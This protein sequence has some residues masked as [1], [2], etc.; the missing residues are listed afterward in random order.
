MTRRGSIAPPAPSKGERKRCQRHHDPR[1]REL[2]H[3]ARR[4]GRRAAHNLWGRRRGRG[5][6]RQ[7]VACLRRA[8]SCLPPCP[9]MARDMLLVRAH[10]PWLSSFGT[11]RWIWSL[12]L[13]LTTVLTTKCGRYSAV[14][15]ELL[16]SLDPGIRLILR[17]LSGQGGIPQHTQQRTHN[18]QVSG[19]SPLVGSR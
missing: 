1:V 7:T 17:T 8:D 4:M 19:S 6:H 18:E 10:T 2:D 14:N 13:T 9:N 5:E 15:G 3:V 16:F 11:A 12:G